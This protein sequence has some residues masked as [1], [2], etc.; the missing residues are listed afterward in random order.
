MNDSTELTD[1]PLPGL[2]GVLL[3]PLP[4]LVPVVLHVKPVLCEALQ[5]SGLPQQPWPLPRPSVGLA[6]V[7]TRP[8]HSNPENRKQDY[9]FETFIWNLILIPWIISSFRPDSAGRVNC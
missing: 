7:K 6:L 1:S 4:P 8:P 2:L 9:K 3:P 5:Q